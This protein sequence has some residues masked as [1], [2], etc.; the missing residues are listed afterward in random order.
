[1]AL[2]RYYV[3]LRS[4]PIEDRNKLAQKLNNYSFICTSFMDKIGLY[5]VF[6]DSATSISNAL[7]I[8]E[9][10]IFTHLPEN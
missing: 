9:K 5:E 4:Y 7:N 8:P 1:M 3:D 2:Q 10:Y 6:W